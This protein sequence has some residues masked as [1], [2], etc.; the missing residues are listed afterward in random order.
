MGKEVMQFFEEF[1]S[2]ES[3]K[4]NLS[5]SFMFLIPK[6]GVGWH[7]EFNASFMFIIP[8]KSGVDEI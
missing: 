5:A 3:I 2:E 6:S 7:L 8:K 1:N 4:H